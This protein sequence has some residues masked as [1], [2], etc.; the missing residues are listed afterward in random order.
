MDSS[1]EEGGGGVVYPSGVH[2]GDEP[3]LDV[4][5]SLMF[6]GEYISSVGGN[7]ENEGESSVFLRASNVANDVEI[8]GVPGRGLGPGE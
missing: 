2:V 6:L 1:L 8:N 5:E 4:L 7:T 3:K